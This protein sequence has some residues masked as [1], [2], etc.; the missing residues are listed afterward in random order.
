M[1]TLVKWGFP[2]GGRRS[3]WGVGGQFRPEGCH[4]VVGMVGRVDGRV[5]VGLRGDPSP[6]SSVLFQMPRLLG[7]SFL[8]LFLFFQFFFLSWIP[9]SLV[10]IL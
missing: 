5:V 10:F 8:F 3:S 2:M 7:M 9:L 6:S 1:A 4:E